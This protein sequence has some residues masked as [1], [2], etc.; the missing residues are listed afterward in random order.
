MTDKDLQK[1]KRIELLEILIEQGK[2]IERL[3]KE[4]AEANKKLETKNMNLTEAGSIADAAMQITGIFEAAQSAAHI[5][6][7]NVQQMEKSTKERCN[8]MERDTLEKCGNMER[9][10]L[11]K[12]QNMIIEAEKGVE[13]KW[14]EISGRLEEFYNTHRGMKEMLKML[15]SFVK[16]I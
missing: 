2:T 1:L 10:T 16:D 11:E 5:Y 8:A 4:L 13:E 12:C 3:E 14:A 9:E 7:E 6:L 15:G